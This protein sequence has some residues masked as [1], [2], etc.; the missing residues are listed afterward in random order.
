MLFHLHK[1]DVTEKANR[2][3][4]RPRA[5]ALPCENSNIVSLELRLPAVW[6]PISGRRD[7]SSYSSGSLMRKEIQLADRAFLHLPFLFFY[8]I[9]LFFL[10]AVQPRC[11]QLL[12]A[13]KENNSSVLYVHSDCCYTS[14][15]T[16]R[17]Y[18]FG[19]LFLISSSYHSSIV[20]ID[21]SSS[22]FDHFFPLSLPHS[23][24]RSATECNTD[25]LAVSG[26]FERFLQG[27]TSLSCF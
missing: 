11:K 14:S 18:F 19:D 8:R 23:F 15:V 2:N 26:Y 21:R 7:A 5:C 12:H 13:A 20:D 9:F 6:R 1:R 3:R 22:D 24:F 27:S 16:S 17:S 10:T 4:C 25:T